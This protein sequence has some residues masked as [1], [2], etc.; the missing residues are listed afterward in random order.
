MVS[1]S[2]NEGRN[3]AALE[4]FLLPLDIADFSFDATV[5]YGDIRAELERQ[6][7]PIGPL[8][9]MIAVT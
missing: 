6:G 8:D 5:A 4:A 3:Q 2:E 7:R 9:T 1:K